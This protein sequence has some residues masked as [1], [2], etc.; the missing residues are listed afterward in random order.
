MTKL[1]IYSVGFENNRIT[2][3]GFIAEIYDENG[4]LL[5]KVSTESGT[6]TKNENE[7]LA[8]ITALQYC[9][10]AFPMA[11]VTIKSA[12]SLVM[13]QA[14]RRARRKSENTKALFLNLKN[15]E[16]LLQGVKYEDVSKENNTVIAR[17]RAE[18]TKPKEKKN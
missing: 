14:N 9:G 15:S 5:S 17:L 8:M 7:Y 10:K 3:G 2:K 4:T 1:V 6:N 18:L 11:E 12:N 13:S 16:K